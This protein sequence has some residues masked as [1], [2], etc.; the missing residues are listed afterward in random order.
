MDNNIFDFIL[1]NLEKNCIICNKIE[2][3]SFICLICGEKICDKFSSRKRDL[4]TISHIKHIYECCVDS[5]IYMELNSS[6]LYYIDLRE[7]IKLKL[8]PLY[9]DQT[10]AGPE[11]REITKEFNLSKEKLKL[12][13]LNYVCND[14]HFK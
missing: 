7:D 11:N 4:D 10:G 3:N 2:K 1:K 14:F 9:V 8:Y 13:L 12:T 5:C 6:K